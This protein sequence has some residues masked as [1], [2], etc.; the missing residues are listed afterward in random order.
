VHSYVHS[1]GGIEAKSGEEIDWAAVEASPVRTP[2]PAAEKRMIRAIDRARKEGDTLGG[3]FTV[4][5]TGVPVGLGTYAQ[6][7]QR[8]DGQLAQAICSV[9]AVKAVELGAG[10]AAA[11]LPGS[12]VHDQPRY[13]KSRGFYHLS[14]RQ[15]GLTGGVTD[16]M[17]VVVSGYLKPISTL[18]K[19]LTTVDLVS[20]KEIQAHYE[21]SDVCVVPAAGV[22]GEAMVALTLARALQ[23]KTG[24]DTIRE[25]RRSLNAFQRT[26]R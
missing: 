14:N 6:W 4:V 7:D 11:R 25:M 22:I 23:A 2:D 18:R 19:P 13:S 10:V 20:R 3:V 17:P 26:V 15:G 1:L 24:G 8:L 9:P 16:G 12:Q 5:A 21:R